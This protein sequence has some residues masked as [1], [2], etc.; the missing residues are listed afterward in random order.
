MKN[1]KKTQRNQDVVKH[2][3]DSGSTVHPLEPKCNINQHSAQ[4]I[5]GY[6]YGLAAQFGADFR[7]DDLHVDDGERAGVE[8]I[9]QCGDHACIRAGGGKLAEVGY[10][11]A[12]VAVAILRELTAELGITVACAGPQRQ[13]V[14]ARQNF[15]DGVSPGSVEILLAGLAGAPRCVERIEDIALSRV[16]CLGALPLFLK[17]DQNFVRIGGGDIT[18]RNNCEIGNSQLCQAVANGIDGGGCRKAYVNNRTPFKIN[19]IE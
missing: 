5:Q 12:V 9:A 13:G 8:R 11:S 14:L 18:D 1:G 19:A 2:C 6:Q 10:D 3:K 4:R 7:A 17:V 16:K 15:C